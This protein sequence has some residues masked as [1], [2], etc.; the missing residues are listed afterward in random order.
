MSMFHRIARLLIFLSRMPSGVLSTNHPWILRHTA[1]LISRLPYDS[2][3]LAN[4][5]DT[6]TLAIFTV[7]PPNILDV[8]SPR[9]D[10][11]QPLGIPPAGSTP[12]GVRRR[13]THLMFSPSSAG[14]F[15]SR[16]RY[17]DSPVCMCVRAQA[18]GGGNDLS[19][20]LRGAFYYPSVTRY[21]LFLLW[22][23]R[24][25]PLLV[26]LSAWEGRGGL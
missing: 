5:L 12:L 10:S 23:P 16:H 20:P 25:G 4:T 7:L 18:L 1:S 22:P 8:F 6:V 11:G 3:A 13:P 21:A 2:R 9:A 19:R 24:S 17:T 26:G 14:F 15:L